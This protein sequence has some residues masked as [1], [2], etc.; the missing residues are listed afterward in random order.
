MYKEI[1]FANFWDDYYSMFESVVLRPSSIYIQLL[2]S[3]INL[4]HSLFCVL[5]WNLQIFSLT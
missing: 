1:C 3:R 4:Q 5:N 2:Q